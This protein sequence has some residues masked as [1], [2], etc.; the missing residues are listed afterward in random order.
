MVLRASQS[1]SDAMRSGAGM[2]EQK[3][4]RDREAWARAQA[5]L[6]RPLHATPNRSWSCPDGQLQLS[7][8][9]TILILAAATFFGSSWRQLSGWLQRIFSASCC[10]IAAG[11]MAGFLPYFSNLSA[12]RSFW[13]ATPTIDSFM[14]PTA[15]HIIKSLSYL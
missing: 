14:A 13:Q 5:T 3:E 9:I 7:I 4:I 6:R 11:V 8:T 10:R 2:G 1:G 15:T 12:H